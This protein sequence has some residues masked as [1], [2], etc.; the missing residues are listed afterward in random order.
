MRGRESGFGSGFFVAARTAL[1]TV[2]TIAAVATLTAAE[3]VATTKAGAPA[4]GANV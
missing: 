2:T 4:R 3:A 1:A